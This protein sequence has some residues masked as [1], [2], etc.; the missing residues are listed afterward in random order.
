M[1]RLK[2]YAEEQEEYKD[3]NDL[4]FKSRKDVEKVFR[5]L[6]RHFQIKSKTTIVY[7]KRTNGGAVSKYTWSPY[8]TLH[9]PKIK[10]VRLYTL[11][12]EMAHILS[13]SRYNYASHDKTHKRLMAMIC[14]YIRKKNYFSSEIE[15]K[16][17]Y[18]EIECEDVA[19]YLF[20]NVKITKE[21]LT[22]TRE[23]TK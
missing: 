12:H 17:R 6:Y 23:E 20:D 7:D 13:F 9:L 14:R 5:K 1:A 21:D 19:K 2:L 10:K 22:K 15:Y 3:L 11:A 4:S 16:R 8:L 18:I